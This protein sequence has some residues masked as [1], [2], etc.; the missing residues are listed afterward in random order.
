MGDQRVLT[1]LQAQRINDP[2][3]V[4]EIARVV[5]VLNPAVV[6]NR[7]TA[8]RQVEDF[9]PTAVL[10][11]EVRQLDSGAVVPFALLLS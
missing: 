11:V 9:A 4:G 5:T 6:D 7:L 1:I 3:T 10:R 2:L 8:A